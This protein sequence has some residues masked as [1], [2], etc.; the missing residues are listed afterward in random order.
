MMNEE[1]LDGE[2][3]KKDVF[4]EH[5]REHVDEILFKTT[6]IETLSVQAATVAVPVMV[7]SEE[8]L[9]RDGVASVTTGAPV[10]VMHVLLE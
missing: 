1:G 7:T 5:E 3:D 10:E 6:T 4:D 9:I 8:T 2:K